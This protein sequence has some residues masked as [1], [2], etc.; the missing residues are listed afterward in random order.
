M[1]RPSSTSLARFVPFRLDRSHFTIQRSRPAISRHHLH[2]Y[3]F[4]TSLTH[5][6][7]H[8]P[9]F[10]ANPPP[11]QNRHHAPPPA[12]HAPAQEQRVERVRRR[13]GPPRAPH[14]RTGPAGRRGEE[15]LQHRGKKRLFFFHSCSNSERVEADQESQ[16]LAFPRTMVS[17]LAKS[18]VPANT[19]MARDAQWAVWK[20][21]TVFVNYLATKQVP[22]PPLVYDDGGSR[23][24]TAPEQRR[25]TR[26]PRF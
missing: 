16:D 13:R 18:A 19:Q 1:E 25:G 20:S 26:R 2:S 9:Q 15:R 11:P 5:K 23:L 8:H 6:T 17:R 3:S 22:P 7:P 24:T 12:P 14:R 10:R 21:A 4:Y